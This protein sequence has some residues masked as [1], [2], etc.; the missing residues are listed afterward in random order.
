MILPVVVY[1]HPVLRKVAEDIT[2]DYPQ[3]NNLIENMFQ[4]MHNADGIGLAAPQVGLSIR[5]FVIDLSIMG[6]E[7]PEFAT[8][9][10]A[11][12]NAQ[13]LERAG[14]DVFEEEGCLSIPNIRERVLRKDRVRI[15]YVDENFEEHDEVY[16][17]WIARVIQHEYDHI[18]GRL[19]VD[20]ISPLRRRLI[21]NKLL[22]ISKGKISAG[23]KTKIA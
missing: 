20:L 19:F 18:D 23:Y 3:L 21:K 22:A 17:G 10:K 12:I 16:E 5:L 6:N 15:K 1:G 13:I 7:N 2:P 8:F 11:F 4:T 9:K 14:E